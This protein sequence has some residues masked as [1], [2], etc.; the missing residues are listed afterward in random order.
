MNPQMMMQMYQMMM[1][2][3]SMVSQG[4][5]TPCRMFLFSAICCP[6]A[7]SRDALSLSRQEAPFFQSISFGWSRRR[8]VKD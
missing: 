2:A 4:H 1:A 8:R 5:L 6:G 7:L 3:S